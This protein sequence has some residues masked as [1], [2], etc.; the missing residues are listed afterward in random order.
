MSYTYRSKGTP[1]QH[2]ERHKQN[3][4]R[5]ILAYGKAIAGI[6]ARIT[7]LGSQM[8]QEIAQAIWDDVDVGTVAS[9]AGITYAKARSI[10][11]AFEDL[12]GSGTTAASHVKTLRALTQQAGWLHA[13]QQELRR[14]QE[15]LIVT[16]RET[17]LLD[18]PW[19]ATV[20]GLTIEQ[21]NIL[22]RHPPA[23]NHLTTDTS[24]THLNALRP[25]QQNL[26]DEKK[27]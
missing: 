9:A 19:P 21:V 7:A 2:A 26:G 6:A 17:G 15:Q 10:G 13:E 18:A 1:E 25:S 3:M 4:N 16:A 12:P 24:P 22:S 5:G 8:D 27:Q 11:L 14:R 20:S 23:Q